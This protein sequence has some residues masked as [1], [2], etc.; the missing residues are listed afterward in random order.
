AAPLV[1]AGPAPARRPPSR[2]R[3]LVRRGREGVLAAAPGAV[4][5]RPRAAAGIPF[6]LIHTSP[7]PTTP[8]PPFRTVP[9]YLTAPPR[10]RRA[11]HAPQRPDRPPPRGPRDLRRGL[12]VRA[13]PPG[14]PHGR[15]GRPRGRS[16]A[17]VGAPPPARPLP[18]GRV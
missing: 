5:P 6:T 3:P 8:I 7:S 1:W 12:A 15:R 16:R 13:R 4:G 18:R 17:S 11:D 2:A 10:E 14:L 9:Q